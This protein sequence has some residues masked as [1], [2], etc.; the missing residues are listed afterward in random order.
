MGSTW[1][2]HQK[3]IVAGEIAVLV[4]N[5]MHHFNQ[6]PELE[7]W[8]GAGGLGR[9]VQAILAPL[10]REHGAAPLDAKQGES[11][12]QS[13]EGDTS[14]VTKNEASATSTRSPKRQKTMDSAVDTNASASPTVTP[15]KGG[16]RGKRGKAGT[17]AVKAANG[18]THA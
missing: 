16:K 8:K 2:S 6:H 15:G 4:K 9:K 11:S 5:N 10:L 1:G 7:A 18:S 13:A 14:R 12:A 17:S 3:T